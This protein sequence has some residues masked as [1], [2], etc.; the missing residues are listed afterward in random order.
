MLRLLAFNKTYFREVKTLRVT[1]TWVWDAGFRDN[2]NSSNTS[3]RP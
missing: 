1:D 3:K 2:T